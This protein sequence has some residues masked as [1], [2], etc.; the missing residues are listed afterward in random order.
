MENILK[1]RRIGVL[2]IIEFVVL[3]MIIFLIIECIIKMFF[4]FL[5]ILR[6]V[7]GGRF[8]YLV[9]VDILS[10]RIGYIEWFFEIYIFEFWGFVFF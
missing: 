1:Y 8:L 5:G 9:C 3:K 7:N 2:D 6:K 4:L 10:R